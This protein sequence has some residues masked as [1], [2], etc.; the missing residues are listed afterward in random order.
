MR[1]LDALNKLHPR[2]P[3]NEHIEQSFWKALKDADLALDELYNYLSAMHQDGL[4]KSLDDYVWPPDVVLAK[5]E[6]IIDW[7]VDKRDYFELDLP[8]DC[9]EIIAA[10]KAYIERATTRL[11]VTEI[12]HD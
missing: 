3:L 12:G 6:D 2:P 4:L 11:A 7:I 8:P 10:E 1:K 9:P 5:L